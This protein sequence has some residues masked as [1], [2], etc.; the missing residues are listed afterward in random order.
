MDYHTST[1]E[2]IAGLRCEIWL[3]ITKNFNPD[4]PH[5]VGCYIKLIGPDILLASEYKLGE[6]LVLE[7]DM[8]D[9]LDREIA[10][11]SAEYLVGLDSLRNQA[12]NKLRKLENIYADIFGVQYN[13]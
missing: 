8:K 11:A 1:E 7:E 12:Y 6:M 13:V 10:F 9:P 4:Q 3:G 2:T 5:N